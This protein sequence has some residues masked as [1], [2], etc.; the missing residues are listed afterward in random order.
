MYKLSRRK[1][2]ENNENSGPD[3][4]GHGRGYYIYGN[5]K[6]HFRY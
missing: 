5:R 3:N 2:N 1:N 4:T 6:Y